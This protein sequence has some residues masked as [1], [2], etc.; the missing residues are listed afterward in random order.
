MGG[1]DG[2]D[3][4]NKWIEDVRE[5]A[6]KLRADIEED[7]RS[8]NDTS[9]SSSRAG[10]FER[11]KGFIDENL[12]T[13]SS[14][15]KNFPSNIQELRTRMQQERDARQAEERDIWRRWTGSED[16][17]DHIRMQV[18]RC[19]QE[20]R[21]EAEKSVS[22]LVQEAFERNKYVHSKK[23]FDL[24]QDREWSLG[25]LDQFAAPMLSFGGACYYKPETV[26]NL[27]STAR[28]GWP[29]P[30]QQWLSTEWFKRDPYSPVRLEGVEGLDRNWRAAFED[31]MCAALD[32][33][34]VSQEKFG[35]RMPYGTPQSTYKGPGL[36]WMLSLQ[37]RGI[38]PPQ[39]PELYRSIDKGD[40][41]MVPVLLRA[42][43]QAQTDGENMAQH[44]L[45]EIRRISR[46]DHKALIDEISIKSGPSTQAV[47]RHWDRVP[48][49]VPD[50]EEELYEQML[51]LEE[52]E[53]APQSPP[54]QLV[55]QEHVDAE[56]T[57]QKLN[58]A[59]SD[60]DLD[61]FRDVLDDYY[62]RHGSIAKV[63]APFVQRSHEDFEKADTLDFALKIAL[64]KSKVIPET[65]LWR[66]IAWLSFEDKR[67]FN[68]QLQG[69]KSV[70]GEHVDEDDALFEHVEGMEGKDLEK[71]LA[72]TARISR[73]W[74]EMKRRK[75]SSALPVGAVKRPDV[76]SQL[77]TTET[78]R[79][80][81]GTVTTKV[82][83]KQRFADGREEQHESV[84]TSNEKDG[85]L[86]QRP[87]PPKVE[88]KQDKPSKKGGW[89][90]N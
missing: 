58:E 59:F 82:V 71:M 55:S 6:K 83:L 32:K 33:P 69:K 1:K 67:E 54:A 10:T 22:M 2:G 3:D 39:M 29:A 26:E 73:E 15:F 60:W 37:C 36:E 66:R 38:L 30:R 76:L 9:S 47:A 16:S 85:K 81:D 72:D 84:H 19:T 56:S 79:L 17:P 41:H 42:W 90:W 64:S 57:S 8:W 48:W 70:D 28:W 89:F 25:A 35:M 43:I 14:G 74:E 52:K 75:E 61:G 86:E 87:T 24:Y 34:M 63:V 27:P 88:P 11:F 50:T 18:E 13:L 46:K 53:S 31:L 40:E 51:P 80:P 4:L 45:R 5:Q 77:T 21:R 62:K 68:S 49:K 44:W 23:I 12:Q 20:E 78:T 65:D 7:V